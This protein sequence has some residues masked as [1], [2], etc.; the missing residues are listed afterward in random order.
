MV[1]LACPYPELLLGAGVRAESRHLHAL[2]LA[3]GRS[4]IM[5][6]IV[7]RAL[8]YRDGHSDG[9]LNVEAS[10]KAANGE[11]YTVD[12]RPAYLDIPN[13]PIPGV[14]GYLHGPLAQDRSWECWS[15]YPPTITT[16]RAGQRILILPRPRGREET[17]LFLAQDLAAAER[18]GTAAR[19]RAT[20]VYPAEF[21]ELGS[22]ER[23]EAL[24]AGAAR[25]VDILACPESIAAFDAETE[26]RLREGRKLRP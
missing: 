25:G 4:A 22:A 18:A 20:L 17:R 21:L 26:R 6:G 19:A 10:S 5:G 1:L 9:R 13:E 2:A 11:A 24:R 8:R 23:S 14:M 3:H 15:A 12:A 16:H 7:G